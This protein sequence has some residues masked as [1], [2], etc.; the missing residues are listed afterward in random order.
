MVIW[1]VVILKAIKERK[2]LMIDSFVLIVV[3]SVLFEL[4]FI[5]SITVS[6]DALRLYPFVIPAH[7]FTAYIFNLLISR[8][9]KWNKKKKEDLRCSQK[10]EQL[11]QNIKRISDSLKEELEK[12][13]RGSDECWEKC[14]RNNKDKK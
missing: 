13:K 5:M 1:P 3:A 12:P 14:S 4:I 10:V 6:I 11:E 8:E 7:V 2:N 9:S